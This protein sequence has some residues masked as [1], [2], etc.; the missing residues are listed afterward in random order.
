MI[1][2]PERVV[3]PG[4]ARGI[5]PAAKTSKSPPEDRSATEA[6][7]IV[8]STDWPAARVLN[9]SSVRSVVL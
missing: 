9:A 1:V 8:C 4:V 7:L 6:M 3:V 5:A 2:S